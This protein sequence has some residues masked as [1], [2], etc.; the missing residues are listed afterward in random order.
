MALKPVVANLDG[1]P[2]AFRTE[3]VEK[4]GVGFVLAIDGELPEVTEYKGKVGE[5]R[6][7][8]IAQAK[9][10]DGLKLKLSGFDGVDPQRYREVTARIAELERQGVG[11]GEDVNA[12]V[13][14]QVNA[15]TA[16]LLTKLADIERRESDAK[17]QLARKNVEGSLRDVAS[18]V[19]IND[20]ATGDFIRRGLD[21][22]NLEGKA[23]NGDETVFSRQNPSQPLS[24]EEWALALQE[25]A[26]HL[27]T[28]SS[29]GGARGGDGGRSGS[30]RLI[31]ADPLEVGRNL[32]D[33]ASGK[34]GI[35]R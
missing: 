5:F 19:G 2:E 12:V 16:P 4:P 28:P 25:D 3:Y 10:L 33:V 34:V 26:P 11:K 23:M 13:Q 29:G 35:A 31:S 27:F 15:A 21:V 6:D 18:K 20:K 7:R 9:E 17:Q 14:R 22:F 32:E 8:N 24:M 30:V 1:V